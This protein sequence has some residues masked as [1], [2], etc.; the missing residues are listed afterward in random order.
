M[1]WRLSISACRPAGTA[2]S[3]VRQIWEI[4][5]EILVVL[6]SAYSDYAWEDIVRELGRTDRFLILRKPFDNIEV[7]Q[8]AAALTERWV[9]ARADALTGLLNRRSFRG[10]LAAGMGLL[11]AR[12][13]SVGM[14][15]LDLDYF[16]NINDRYGHQPPAT[17][18]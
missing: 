4:D 9:I 10:A 14:R 3:T 17:R 11:A 5:P 12:R 2:S 13:P 15:L 18:R 1:P 6:C 8:C 7:R 16:K